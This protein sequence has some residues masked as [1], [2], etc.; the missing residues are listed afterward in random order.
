MSAVQCT[1]AETIEVVE[2]SS[3]DGCT[4]C[5]RTGDRW[6]HLRLCLSCGEVACCDSSPNQH[7]SKHATSAGHPIAAS[8]E[9]GE[10]WAW[11]YVD[12][13]MLDASPLGLPSHL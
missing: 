9:P 7:A 6:L 12:E 3:M 2:P 4:E 5:L 1:H 10:D 11:C 13:V 8:F